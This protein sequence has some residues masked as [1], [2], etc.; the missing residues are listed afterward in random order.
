MKIK[1][2]HSRLL[3][4]ACFPCVP[5][6]LFNMA[7]K[8]WIEWFWPFLTPSRWFLG[9]GLFQNVFYN[10]LIYTNNLCFGCLSI[11]NKL[12]SIR[13]RYL[14]LKKTWDQKQKKER[15]GFNTKTYKNS[16]LLILM[17]QRSSF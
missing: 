3:K 16:Q 6:A 4:Y 17:D 1:I 2:E 10:I 13:N 12:N 14:A 7:K 11:L 9:L 5:I 8:S 15:N